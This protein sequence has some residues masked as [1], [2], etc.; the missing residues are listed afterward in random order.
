MICV[1]FWMGRLLLGWI[2]FPATH[3]SH[4]IIM[5]LAITG[6]N[7]SWYSISE[8]ASCSMWKWKR[9]PQFTWCWKSAAQS[10]RCTSSSC[11]ALRIF[12]ANSVVLVALNWFHLR[13]AL[14]L[15][16]TQIF[17]GRYRM[18]TSYNFRRPSNGLRSPSAS[19]KR[20]AWSPLWI[21]WR[22][23]WLSDEQYTSNTSIPGFRGFML[24]G[25]CI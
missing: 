6:A 3:M 11:L 17:R 21:L 12:W 16:D 14:R 24:K 19:P 2:K 25:W 22:V 8:P 23:S 5:V 13:Q 20:T 1:P 4:L 7:A 15:G 10:R 9:S 18:I